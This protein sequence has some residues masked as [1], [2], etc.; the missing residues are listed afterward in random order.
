MH[1]ILDPAIQYARSGFPV[2]EVIAWSWALEIPAREKFPG[3]IE[4]YTIEG[5][6]PK[7]GEIF[8]NPNLANTLEKIALNGRDFFYKGDIAKKIETEIEYPGQIKVVL[9]R[10]FRGVDYA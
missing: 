2:S 7:K 4:T 5:R 8:I 3:F 6:T 10:E 9:I 1:E